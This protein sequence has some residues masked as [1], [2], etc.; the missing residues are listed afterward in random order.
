M[1]EIWFRRCATFEE[2]AAADAEFW[3]E[4]TP[5]ERVALVDQMRREGI[6]ADGGG[7]EGLRR[8]VRVIKAPWS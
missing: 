1:R 6:L 4:M 8:V 7:D 5:D 2:E 3:A